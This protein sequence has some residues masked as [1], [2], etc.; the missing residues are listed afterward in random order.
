MDYAGKSIMDIVE[1]HLSP[2]SVTAGGK[3]RFG[4]AEIFDDGEGRVIDAVT[5]SAEYAGGLRRKASFIR[6][7]SQGRK[8]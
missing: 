6:R 7:K 4:A 2:V 8:R 3:K 5:G 1:E